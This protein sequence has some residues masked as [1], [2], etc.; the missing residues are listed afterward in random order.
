MRKNK[1]LELMTKCTIIIIV[2]ICV[3]LSC[4]KQAIDQNEEARKAMI[5]L[6]NSYIDA[7]KELNAEKIISCYSSSPEFMFYAD[8]KRQNYDE[9]VDDVWDFFANIKK[10]KGK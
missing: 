9:L 4:N 2:F 10:Y 3:L 1:I 7:I 6:M 5:T 8:G